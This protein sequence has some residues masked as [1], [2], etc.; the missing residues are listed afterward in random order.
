MSMTN[1]HLFRLSD[2]QLSQKTSAAFLLALSTA[3]ARPAFTDCHFK[4][5]I[6]A[7]VN[8]SM[9]LNTIIAPKQKKPCC[10][11]NK[12]YVVDNDISSDRTAGNDAI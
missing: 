3:S 10:Y 12:K 9:L 1:H 8:N 5:L 2:S 6:L 7:G 4:C 11:S